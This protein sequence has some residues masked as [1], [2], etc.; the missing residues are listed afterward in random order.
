MGPEQ[1]LV[2]PG[3]GQNARRGPADDQPADHLAA[4]HL[5]ADHLAAQDRAGA[6]R[7]PGTYSGTNSAPTSFRVN[8]AAC[9]VV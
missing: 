7:L 9:S 5:A 1:R 4:D 2:L 3:R 8:D 6:E